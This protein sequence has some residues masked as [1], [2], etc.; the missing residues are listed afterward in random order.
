MSR[1][2]VLCIAVLLAVRL[3]AAVLAG[4][5]SGCPLRRREQR[6]RD[7]G[8]R[9]QAVQ[10]CAAPFRQAGQGHRSVA[11]GYGGLDTTFCKEVFTTRELQENEC[12]EL[13]CSQS[14]AAH[15]TFVYK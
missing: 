3:R 1:R 12:Y 8:G 15:S 10:H 6:D 5:P 4:V 14:S 11:E 2:S 7:Q 13:G 9:L